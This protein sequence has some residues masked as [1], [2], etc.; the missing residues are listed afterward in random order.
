[1]SNKETSRWDEAKDWEE[2]CIPSPQSTHDKATS[3]RLLRGAPLDLKSKVL[4]Q[5]GRH[6]IL[7]KVHAR[8]YLLFPVALTG[9]NDL[10]LYSP[11]KV[12][13]K[14]TK[15]STSSGLKSLFF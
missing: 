1:M 6:S 7:L 8:N 11:V 10:P 12:F 4:N 2:G 15:L 14:A 13:K 5:Q 3:L 9:I